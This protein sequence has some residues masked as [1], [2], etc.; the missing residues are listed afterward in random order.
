MRSNPS[1]R[2]LLATVLVL[3]LGCSRSKV[4]DEETIPPDLPPEQ[5][6]EDLRLAWNKAG[7]RSGWLALDPQARFSPGAG[8]GKVGEVWAFTFEKWPGT[9][10]MAKL[11]EPEQGFG[12]GLTNTFGI[13][14]AELKDLARFKQLQMLHLGIT[15]VSDTGLKQVAGFKQLKGL[16]L[17]QTKVTDM[18]LQELAGLKKLQVLE[19]AG[20][21]VTDAG[22]TELAGLKE[23]RVLDLVFTP[24][25]DKGLKQLAGLKR[26]Q[27][28]YLKNTSVTEAGAAN[29]Q[30]T[31]PS[32]KIIR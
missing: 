28:L 25:T 7:A 19:L 13:T 24:V 30:R 16:D 8:S 20:T 15:K 11:P 29:L 4:E 27:R 31:L 10:V 22:L 17:S 18:G 5:L 32:L 26:L 6:P 21:A 3:M 12:I 23:L 9:D 1:L 2:A 14:D